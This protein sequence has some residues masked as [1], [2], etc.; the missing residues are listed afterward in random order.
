MVMAAASL[1]KGQTAPSAD[2]AK[3]PEVKEA[4][5]KEQIREMNSRAK[6]LVRYLQPLVKKYGPDVLTIVSATTADGPK[7]QFEKMKIE[8]RDLAAVKRLLWSKLE[9]DKYKFEIL[10]ETGETLK[11]KVTKCFLAEAFLAAGDA[12]IGAAVCCAWDYGFCQGVNPQI[13]FT[14]TKTLM[15][16]DE[17]CNHSYELKSV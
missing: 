2:P 5:K 17:Y 1:A 15:K 3:S 6:T 16:G 7:A 14:R 10:E 12:E 8:K 11:C 4:L 13:K 9:P